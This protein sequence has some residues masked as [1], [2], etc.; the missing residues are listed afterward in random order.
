[1]SELR[2][3]DRSFGVSELVVIAVVT[4]GGDPAADMARVHEV[5]AEGA[6]VVEVGGGLGLGEREEIER[7]VPFLATVRDA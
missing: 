2:L 4:G 6:D 1:M 3:G 7:T 5:V